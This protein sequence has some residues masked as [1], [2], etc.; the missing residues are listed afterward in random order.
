MIALEVDKQLKEYLLNYNV[1]IKLIDEYPQITW[2]TLDNIVLPEKLLSKYFYVFHSNFNHFDSI[3]SSSSSYSSL[4]FF[5]GS[6]VKEV[7]I[8]GMYTEDELLNTL[9]EGNINEEII[10]FVYSHLA[11][12]IKN[13]VNNYHGLGLLR[14]ELD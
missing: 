14:S 11:P 12:F 6:T 10:N 9:W 8:I 5:F 3:D 2:F 7:Q 13:L 4:S 1:D